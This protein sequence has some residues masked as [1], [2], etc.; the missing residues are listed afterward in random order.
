MKTKTSGYRGYTVMV[1]NGYIRDIPVP[2]EV[3]RPYSA[4]PHKHRHLFIH[5]HF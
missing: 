5:W 3:E 4:Q 2:L 1:Q